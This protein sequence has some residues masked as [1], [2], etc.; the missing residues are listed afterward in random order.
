MLSRS[1][2]ILFVSFLPAG[3][4][5]LPLSPAHTVNAVV[6]GIL[7]MLLSG[8]SLVYDRARIGTAI[9]GA[10]V[11]LT[12]FIF[13]STLLEEV[14]TVCWGT[15]MFATMTGPF[16]ASPRTFRT[17]AAQPAEAFAEERPQQMAA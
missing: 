8:L 9:I 15:L 3:A 14:L 1:I 13:P 7:A 17:A 12:A 16:S 5:I 4:L 2:G 11:A 6:A 10:W